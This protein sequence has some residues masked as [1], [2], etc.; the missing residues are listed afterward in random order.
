MSFTEWHEARMEDLGY[1]EKI[2]R[3]FR[4]SRT[5]FFWKSMFDGLPIKVLKWPKL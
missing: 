1:P 5:K 2:R 3:E 4:N